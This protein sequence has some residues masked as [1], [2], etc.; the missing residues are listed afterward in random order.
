[1]SLPYMSQFSAFYLNMFCDTQRPYSSYFIALLFVNV[2]LY[3]FYSIAACD[4]SHF[5]LMPV[6]D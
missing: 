6:C 3:E 1:M 5:I 4:A 2:F